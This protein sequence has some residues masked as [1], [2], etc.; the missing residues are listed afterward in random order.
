MELTT[1]NALKT[2]KKHFEFLKTIQESKNE[3]ITQT[4]NS[5]EFI[6]Q[7][8][9]LY[10]QDFCKLGNIKLDED[11]MSDVLVCHS[12]S[13]GEKIYIDEGTWLSVTTDPRWLKSMGRR[14]RQSDVE[15]VKSIFENHSNPLLYYSI[16]P[17]YYELVSGHIINEVPANN[18]T[19]IKPPSFITVENNLPYYKDEINTKDWKSVGYATYDEHD[20]HSILRAQF[21]LKLIS[22]EPDEVLHYYRD[23]N[24]WAEIEENVNNYRVKSKTINDGVRSKLNK[25]L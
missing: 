13:N 6:E 20:D 4:L 18:S 22:E 19:I 16:N 24:N 23:A 8:K 9:K 14:I 11:I 1:L 12:S 3:N 10:G 2:I 21:Y 5:D 25:S 17:S 15:Y 7:F